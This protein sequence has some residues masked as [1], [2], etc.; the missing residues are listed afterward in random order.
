MASCYTDRQVK[1]RTSSNL[2]N[3]RETP[4]TV[5]VGLT[6]HGSTR[7]KKMVEMFHGLGCSI[8]YPRV[9]RLETQ[10]AS[11]VIENMKENSGIYIPPVI[12]Q[13]RFIHC[14]ADNID[15]CEDTV[16]GKR[17]LHGTIMTVYQIAD[18]NDK[19]KA[20]SLKPSH[21]R[22][23]C[24]IDDVLPDFIPFHK[25]T[26][27]TTCCPNP[28]L[29]QDMVHDRKV[30][31][32]VQL[33]NL[34]WKLLRHKCISEEVESTNEEMDVD[35]ADSQSQ[36]VMSSLT[37]PGYMSLISETKSL[38]NVSTLP[39]FA[40]SP[41]DQSV[42]LTLMNQLEKIN[43]FILGPGK[44]VVVTLDIALYKPVKQLEM[45]Q[46]DY[47]RKWLLKPGELHIF[48]AMLPT[49]GDFIQNS[50]I[51]GLWTESNLYGTATCRQI[52]EGKHIR[53]GLEAHVTTL[54]SLSILLPEEF[55]QENPSVL[56][57][58]KPQIADLYN[59]LKKEDE[60]DIKEVHLKFV[61]I[62]KEH[63]ILEKLHQFSKERERNEPVFKFART[64]IDIVE[65]MLTYVKAVR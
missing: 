48:I 29:Y 34:A 59:A 30:L 28:K 39:L 62:L 2:Y 23:L 54:S 27:W 5:G 50:G 47:Q 9:L 8:D 6:V 14:A 18:R 10:I 65:S 57:N 1:N 38:S 60:C 31:Y 22:S 42:Q 15:F 25:P 52:L 46:E 11:S 13:G 17:T 55:S 45:A 61:S 64:Y 37:W 41:T 53:R 32:D 19:T 40:A 58:I 49:I 33:T 16:D 56:E 20:L 51:P 7:S 63:T 4:L 35:N 12:V 21:Q 24:N 43:S 26:N 44:K 3:V 36:H